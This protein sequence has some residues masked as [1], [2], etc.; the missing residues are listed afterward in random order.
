M[1]MRDLRQRGSDKNLLADSCYAFTFSRGSPFRYGLLGY[2]VRSRVAEVD[3]QRTMC[4][5]LQ[6][7]Q[8]P[9]LF[10]PLGS[11]FAVPEVFLFPCDV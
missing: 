1:W 11:A 4:Y 3:F 6:T 2:R 10:M 5:S 9:E 7:L 8:V